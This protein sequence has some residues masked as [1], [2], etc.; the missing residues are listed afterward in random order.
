MIG[1][2]ESALGK[3]PNCDTAPQILGQGQWAYQTS[4]CP[5]GYW[6]VLGCGGFDD[7]AKF[8]KWSPLVSGDY[9]IYTSG[10]RLS[11]FAVSS[12]TDC[13]I[14][15]QYTIACS[16]FSDAPIILSGL[17][18]GSDFL[19]EVTTSFNGEPRM[20]HIEKMECSASDYV[21]DGL[22]END[23]L[24]NAAVIAEGI[25]TDLAV[26]FDDPDY[27]Q[28]LIPAGEELLVKADPSSSD[29]QVTLY[30]YQR[31]V[32]SAEDSRQVASHIPGANVARRAFIGVEI[33]SVPGVDNCSTYDLHITTH[34]IVQS[35]QTFCNPATPNSTGV[36]T[37]L[38]MTED[39]FDFHTEA[40][41][42]AFAVSGPPG[43]FGYLISGDQ[44]QQLG[45]PMGAQGICIGGN[46]GRYNV[47]GT[48]LNSTG[49][50]DQSG[51]WRS[52]Y[53]SVSINTATHWRVRAYPVPEQLPN[54]LGA[55][56]VGQS[57][58]FQLWH[59]ENNGGSATSNGVLVNW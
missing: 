41:V 8:W 11:S 40:T 58:G 39:R 45:L 15:R 25:H 5:S 21:E 52:Y 4:C 19:I 22:E 50:F 7:T 57:W 14:A 47:V 17:S 23:S 37:T 30:D 12:E 27:Y 13:S 53:G 33:P 48:S 46:I 18:A 36:P 43:Q 16:W 10:I 55:L 31:Q 49:V 38:Y 20:L 9:K 1:V 54:G 51:F 59:R 34:P 42:F 56:V 26:R 35:Y 44:V 3:H 28:V 29:V 24:S 32:I 2:S 6:S